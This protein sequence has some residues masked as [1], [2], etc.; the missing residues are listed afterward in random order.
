MPQESAA[1][2]GLWRFRDV[3]G[4]G[5]VR[6]RRVERCFCA[7]GRVSRSLEVSALLVAGA[8][9]ECSCLRI[10]KMHASLAATGGEPARR[11][12]IAV[13]GRR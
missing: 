5:E 6:V 13:V 4:A 8:D 3:G 9:C 7:I 11:S 1:A 10:E 12:L 2:R